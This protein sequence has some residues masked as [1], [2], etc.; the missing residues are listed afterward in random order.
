MDVENAMANMHLGDSGTGP[1]SSDT[2]Y[3]REEEEDLNRTP[4]RPS[5]KALGKRKLVDGIVSG[6]FDL[7]LCQGDR[8]SLSLEESQVDSDQEED[9]G[10]LWLHPPVKY[11]YDAAAERTQQ[12]IRD[13]T[14]ALLVNGVH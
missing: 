5:A 10:D 11:V 3:V 6:N 4:I 9:E 8:N 7:N 2:S 12:R 13:A 14:A 1:V